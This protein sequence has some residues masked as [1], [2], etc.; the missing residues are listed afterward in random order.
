MLAARREHPVAS[1]T[2]LTALL[3]F[4]DPGEIGVYVS[5]EYL[6]AREPAL[7]AGARVRGSELANAFASLRPNELVWNYV[8]SNYLKGRTPPAFDLLFWN[9][10]SANFPVRCTPTICATCTS[11]IACASRAP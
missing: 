8:V 9:G 6:A 3:D 4:E 11:T 10:D 5:R 1:A 7:L 2:L